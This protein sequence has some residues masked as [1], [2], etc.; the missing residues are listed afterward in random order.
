MNANKINKGGDYMAVTCT[1]CLAAPQY[2]EESQAT[3][4]G[5]TSHNEYFWYV[6][7][8]DSR[9]IPSPFP[10]SSR[11]NRRRIAARPI[12]NTASTALNVV[13]VL[14]WVRV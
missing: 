5:A 14:V 13:A 4:I 12:P 9:L 2:F 8:L 6:S 11:S 1:S 3:G 7:P 10:P